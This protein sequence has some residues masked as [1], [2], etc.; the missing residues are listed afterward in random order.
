M[1]KFM[2]ATI[3]ALLVLALA[4]CN[5]TNQN[6][7][8]TE[9]TIETADNSMGGS[10]QIPNPFVEYETIEEADDHVD[11]ELKLP[12]NVSEEYELVNISVIENE[13]VQLVYDNGKTELI[14]RQAMGIEDVSGDYSVYNEVNTEMIGDDVVTLSG[15]DSKIKLAIWSEGICSYSL[16]IGL[17]EEG[18]EKNLITN[19]IEGIK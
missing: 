13:L 5:P 14:Y 17:D 6:E 19:I 18:I 4:G 15:E 16:N 1:K 7:A 9:G 2:K 11:F 3:V 8:S 12:N 10:T